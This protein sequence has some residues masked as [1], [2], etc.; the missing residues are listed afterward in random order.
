MAQIIERRIAALHR[1]VEEHPS[2]DD[3]PDAAW[4]LILIRI[5]PRKV[6][7]LRSLW[8]DFGAQVMEELDR[9]VRDYPHSPYAGMAALYRGFVAFGTR[10][11][12][13]TPDRPWRTGDVL[14]LDRSLA[15]TASKYAGSTPGGL[16]LAWRLIVADRSSVDELRPEVPAIKAKID[17]GYGGDSEVQRLM[18]SRRARALAPDAGA[19]DPGGSR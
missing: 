14:A 7:D 8:G 12:D 17:E 18:S 15:E 13:G 1:Y 5:W 16:A 11:E 9:F 3:R 4:N 6:Y 2:A 19:P 10:S